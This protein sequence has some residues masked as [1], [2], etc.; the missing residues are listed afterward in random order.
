[1]KQRLAEINGTLTIET[2]LTVGTKVIAAVKLN[3][4]A[5]K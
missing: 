3:M 4:T 2:T 5:A 1:M